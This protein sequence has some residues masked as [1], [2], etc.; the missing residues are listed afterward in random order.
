MSELPTAELRRRVH[1]IMDP[2]WENFAETGGYTAKRLARHMSGRFPDAKKVAR[3]RVYCW[4]AEKMWLTLDECHVSKFTAEQCHEAIG[5]LSGTDYAEI[6]RWARRRD[7]QTE[8]QAR[9]SAL[10]RGL[11]HEG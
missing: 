2:I 3:E 7:H 6:R 8:T 4:L 1:A 10:H 9:I 5:H 11:H